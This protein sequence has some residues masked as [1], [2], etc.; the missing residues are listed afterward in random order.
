M[1][2]K[3]EA[4]AVVKRRAPV[5]TRV[6]IPG[7]LLPHEPR[8]IVRHRAVAVVDEATDRGAASGVA[9]VL[10]RAGVARAV[11]DV[12]TLIVARRQAGVG[13][14]GRTGRRSVSKTDL[15]LGYSSKH[16]D[17]KVQRVGYVNAAV[18]IA[19]H[20]VECRV[21]RARVVDSSSLRCARNLFPCV[22]RNQNDIRDEGNSYE[23]LQGPL[24]LQIRPRLQPGRPVRRRLIGTQSSPAI[25]SLVRVIVIMIV[26]EILQI[27]VGKGILVVGPHFGTS[28]EFFIR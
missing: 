14:A 2:G 5:E 7:V 22:K 3:L 24:L 27:P 16:P 20:A 8:A 11:D 10:T 13:E 17:E 4:L 23:F 6:A 25:H 21:V 28:F 9:T 26:V 18:S 19:V 12:T 1:A 15:R